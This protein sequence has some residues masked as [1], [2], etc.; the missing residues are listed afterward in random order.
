[1]GCYGVVSSV[2][3]IKVGFYQPTVT[4][5]GDYALHAGE[6]LLVAFVLL[7]GARVTSAESVRFSTLSSPAACSV[8]TLRY[9]RTSELENHDGPRMP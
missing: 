5:L 2:T 6:K 9:I 3:N 8:T 1:V 4:D 7:M